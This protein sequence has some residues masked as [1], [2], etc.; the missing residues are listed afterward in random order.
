MHTVLINILCIEPVK[1]V[2]TIAQFS[3]H[4]LPFPPVTSSFDCIVVD[5]IT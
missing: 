5:P 4:A 3:V 2:N 1:I